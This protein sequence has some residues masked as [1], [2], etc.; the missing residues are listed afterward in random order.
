[1]T[2][3]TAL[4]VEDEPLVAFVAAESLSALGFNVEIAETGAAA[5]AMVNRGVG[6]ETLAVVDVGLPDVRGDELARTMKSISPGLRLVVAS[7]YDA[8]DLRRRIDDPEIAVLAKPY[9][10]TSLRQTLSGLG[11]DLPAA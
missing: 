1:M 9:G 4:L 6:A 3:A 10:E 11:Y 7:G 8:Q 5:L 2:P